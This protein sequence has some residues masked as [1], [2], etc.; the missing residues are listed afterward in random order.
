MIEKPLVLVIA[1]SDPS[2]GAGV[3]ADL[4]TLSDCGVQGISA[5]TAITAQTDESVIAIHPTPADLLS[6][7]LSTACKK[8]IPDA[9]KIGMVATQANIRVIS[10]FLK[11]LATK[12]IVIDPILHSSSGIALLETKAATFYRHELFP[13]ATVITP[14]LPEASAL[15]GM[16]VANPETMKTA[17]KIIHEEVMKFRVKNDRSFAVLIK[18]GHLQGDAVDML[19]D[20]MQF[21]PFV[22]PRIPGKNPRG[23]GCR[24]SSALAASLAK[25]R[26][27]PEATSEAK[28]YLRH[29]I[30]SS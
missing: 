20:G 8:K 16:Q 2:G 1:G 9:V 4:K 11:Q 17:A 14:N 19:Y 12:Y 15:A 18:G 24:F 28:E 26:A 30:A 25:G 6:Q 5:I 3:Q 13:L 7:Q 23:T 29:Y 10:W 27:L 21:L 22:S